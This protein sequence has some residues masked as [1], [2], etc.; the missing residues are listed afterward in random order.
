MGIT[1]GGRYYVAYTEQELMTL[2]A[3]LFHRML[4]GGS[5]NGK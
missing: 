1:F 2:L 5:H 3:T 4:Y